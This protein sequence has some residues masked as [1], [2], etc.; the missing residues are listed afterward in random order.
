MNTLLLFSGGLDS[1]ACLV[2]L[3][4]ET[5][6]SLHIHH[7]HYINP[8][9]RHEAEA[10]AVSKIIPH[11]QRIRSFVYTES[12][13]DYSQI[14]VLS[15]M[16]VTRFTAAQICRNFSIN[17]VVTGKCKEDTNPDHIV[18]AIFKACMS[19]S[20]KVVWYYPM[21]DMTKVE[22]IKYLTKEEPDL[23]A[24]I[25][26]CRKPIRSGSS[27]ENCNK[28]STCKQMIIASASL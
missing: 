15:D 27:W 3:L 9:G 13:Q 25:H 4:K 1:T 24:F 5:D 2:K 21:K 17:R 23:L 28:C 20:S 10:L 22:E 6:D 26:Y 18:D 14:G 12:T 7:I 8:E 19:G 11:C 16:H